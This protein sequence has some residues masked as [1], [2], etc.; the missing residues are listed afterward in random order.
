MEVTERHVR[1][2][3]QAFRDP[4]A[5]GK[6]T[7]ATVVRLNLGLRESADEIFDASIVASSRLVYDT[8]A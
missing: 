1:S 4:F 6:F 8:L 2:L 7:R 5:V 3:D